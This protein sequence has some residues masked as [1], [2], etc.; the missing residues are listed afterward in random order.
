MKEPTKLSSNKVFCSSFLCN[1]IVLI[2]GELIFYLEILNE[3][4]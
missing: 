1:R 2:L 4:Y 3:V